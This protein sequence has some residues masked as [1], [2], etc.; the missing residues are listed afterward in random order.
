MRKQNL[1]NHIAI[2]ADG[3][4]SMGMHMHTV[5]KVVDQQVNYLASRSKEMDQETRGTVYTF[6]DKVECLYYD[7]DVLRLPSISGDYRPQGMTALVDAT[8]Q[9]INDL[10]KTAQLYGD[11]AFLIF[12]ITDGQENQS[13]KHR[14]SELPN[15]ISRLPENWTV[16]TLVPDQRA[17]F[18]AKACGFP[19]G[20]VAVWDIHGDFNEV[21]NTV[22]TATE[23]FMT[24]RSLGVRGTR[25]LFSTAP[26]AVNKKTITAAGLTKVP[27]SKYDMTHVTVEK[28]EAKEWVE[29]LGRRFVLGS[30]YYP[31]TRAEKIQPQKKLMVLEKKTGLVFE[32]D[33]VRPLLN[34]PSEL[35]TV[36]PDHNPDYRIYVQ[37]TAPNRHVHAGWD[38]ILMR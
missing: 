11:H 7:M 2:V 16:A 23:S 6:A 20:N 4:S 38:I 14:A 28:M 33:G 24:S 15:L 34:L 27:T 18:A 21:G 35:V 37:S 30:L 8:F 31:L 25:S 5:V 19:A 26:D 17:V 13:R 3:S 9:A 36:K 1:I 22:R 29:S 10:E 12:V 32:G